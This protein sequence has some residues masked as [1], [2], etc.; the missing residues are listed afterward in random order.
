MQTIGEAGWQD[1][2]DMEGK[3]GKWGETL[4]GEKGG[5]LGYKRGMSVTSEFI[6]NT[7]SCGISIKLWHPL[8]LVI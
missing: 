1:K 6:F 8:Y 4:S 3:G 5:K 7:T 2:C